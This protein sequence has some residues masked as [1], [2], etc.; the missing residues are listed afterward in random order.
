[1]EVL[2]CS[3]GA[4]DQVIGTALHVS[5]EHV[6]GALM[7]YLPVWQAAAADGGCTYGHG[8]APCAPAGSVKGSRKARRQR[9]GPLRSMGP[10]REGADLWPVGMY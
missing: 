6:T 7:L 9:A 4:V 10:D 8:G 1:M 3:G 2:I 5:T